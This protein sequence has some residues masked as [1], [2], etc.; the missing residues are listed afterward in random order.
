MA[1]TI[2]TEKAIIYG[3]SGSADYFI[4]DCGGLELTHT[5][6]GGLTDAEYI[7]AVKA[8]TI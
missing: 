7:E 6:D 4:N 1:I 3:A 5:E 2:N 8:L